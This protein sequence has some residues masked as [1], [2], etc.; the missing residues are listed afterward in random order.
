MQLQDEKVKWKNSRCI[1]LTEKYLETM[2][3]VLNSS[4]IFSQ[5]FRHCRFF[6]RFRMICE[7]VTSNLKNSHQLS[8]YGAVTNWCAQFGLKV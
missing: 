6:K 1:F 2:E 5:D 8:I 3:K 7:D 4:G